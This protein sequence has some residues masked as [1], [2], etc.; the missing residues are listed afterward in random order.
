MDYKEIFGEELTPKIEEKL[1]DKKL[2]IHSPE[3][4]YGNLSDGSYIPAEKFSNL[5]QEKK[6]LQKQ[7]DDL[8]Q[9]VGDL[10]KFS[11]ENETLKAELDK[12][13][14]ETE[15]F[16][17]ETQK[18]LE[19][20]KTKFELRSKIMLSAGENT[21]LIMATYFSDNEFIDNIPKVN[22]E[23]V[24]FDELMKPITEKHGSLFSTGNF[25]GTPPPDGDNPNGQRGLGAL[26]DAD[27]LIIKNT[28]L[29]EDAVISIKKEDKDKYENLKKTYARK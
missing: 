26:T 15:S 3:E 22:N 14:T 18:E 7:F 20:E 2:I 25:N 12:I 9:R 6:A 16:K 28:G 8:N 23:I 11:S 1:G 27:E 17:T 29:T 19:R 4:K 21:D 13:K 10:D 5:N 24:G